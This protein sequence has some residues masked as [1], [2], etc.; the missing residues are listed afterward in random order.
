LLNTGYTPSN[1]WPFAFKWDGKTVTTKNINMYEFWIASRNSNFLFANSGGSVAPVPAGGVLL[2]VPVISVSGNNATLDSTTSTG[3]V[4]TC[5]WYITDANGNYKNNIS[6][7]SLSP[8]SRKLTAAFLPGNYIARL[9]L[10]GPD[11]S[12]SV[13]SQNFSVGSITPTPPVFPV[14]FTQSGITYTLA[15]DGTFKYA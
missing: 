15:A 9:S 8:N 4:A 5:D 13:V 11:G 1:R 2:A 6:A 7:Q 14:V 10:W 12:K 3:A